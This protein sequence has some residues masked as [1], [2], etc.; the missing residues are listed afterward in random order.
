M[1]FEV[2]VVVVVVVVV[3]VIVVVVAGGRSTHRT[4]F[5]LLKQSNSSGLMSPYK[6]KCCGS[7]PYGWAQELTGLQLMPG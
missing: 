4:R 5:L 1:G 7:V 3:V 6:T 2:A